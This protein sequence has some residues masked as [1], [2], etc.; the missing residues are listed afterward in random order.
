ME[1][2]TALR[3]EGKSS[4]TAL[5]T[6]SRLVLSK[7]LVGSKLSYFHSPGQGGVIGRRS[8][9][10]ETWGSLAVEQWTGLNGVRSKDSCT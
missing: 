1:L 2:G 7:S 3:R 9:I 4:Q 10:N 6:L 8:P 5:W